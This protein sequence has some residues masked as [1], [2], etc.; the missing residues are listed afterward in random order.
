[1]NLPT[2]IDPVLIA[3][4]PN[5]PTTQVPRGNSSTQPVIPVVNHP[6]PRP[7][8]QVPRARPTTTTRTQRAAPSKPRAK[9]NKETEEALLSG[10][11]EAKEKG[12]QSDNGFKKAGWK[13]ASPPLVGARTKARLSPSTEIFATSGINGKL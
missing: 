6:N 5:P 8:A 3:G 9:W 13:I 10:L 4:P 12:H 7:N 2:P 1:M 11:V